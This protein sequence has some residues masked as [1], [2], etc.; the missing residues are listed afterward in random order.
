MCCQ[1]SPLFSWNSTGMILIGKKQIKGKLIKK[2]FKLK[3]TQNNCKGV[4]ETYC[5]LPKIQQG[6]KSLV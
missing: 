1:Q 4:M 6:S 3:K 2:K 5:K